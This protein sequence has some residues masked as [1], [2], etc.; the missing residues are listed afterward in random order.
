MEGNLKSPR[1][2]RFACIALTA[3][4]LW[5]VFRQVDFASLGSAFRSMKP[6]WFLAA[7]VVFG[8][9]FLPAAFRL[10][11]IFRLAGIPARALETLRTCL[12][13]H[14]FYVVLF[15]AVGGDAA[16]S[17]WYARQH[18]VSFAE[19]LATAPLDRLLSFCGLL[20]F[21]GLSFGLAAAGGAFSALSG[22]H[23]KWPTWWLALAVVAVVAGG[24][25][26]RGKNSHSFVGRFTS[27]L[28][29][30]G[31]LL[32]GAPRVTL[33]GVLC[34]LCVQVALS[35]TLALNLQSVSHATLDWERLVWT[36]PVISIIGS[37]PIAVAGV[38]PREGAAL[39]LFGLYGV[40][41]PDAVAAS[42]LTLL[43]SLVWA[44]VGG[45]LLWKAPP[46]KPEAIP[47]I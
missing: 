41:A 38:G 11:L 45:L 13:G 47:Q 40:P 34:G 6:A 21:L 20:L 35:G 28:A 3:L 10:H 19:I 36:L 30:I 5:L 23:F 26:L 29:R 8:L 12:I 32:A 37:L 27:A 44:G 25:F 2:L 16:R 4:A 1:W 22:L 18:R 39:V 7:V 17:A 14:L 42:L 15:G 24:F 33:A 43:A 46:P 31:K 9:L